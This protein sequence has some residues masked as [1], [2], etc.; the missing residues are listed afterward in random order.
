LI[1]KFRENKIIASREFVNSLFE[2][3]SLNRQD[4]S[5]AINKIQLIQKSTV[6]DEKV[7]KNIFYSSNEDDNFE[8][9]NFC[10]LGDKKI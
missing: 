2:T 10:L 5:D 7:L 1:Q 3:N 6:V 4:I 9:I 8:I